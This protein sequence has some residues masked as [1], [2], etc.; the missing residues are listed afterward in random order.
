MNRIYPTAAV[1]TWSWW[2]WG[3]TPANA[4]LLI[5]ATCLVSPYL[6]DY[7]LTLLA[8]AVAL[9]AWDGVKTGRWL[10]WEREVYLSVAILPA[11]MA[12]VAEN[13]GIQVG[14]FAPLAVLVYAYMR[15]S[16]TLACSGTIG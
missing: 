3:V 12:G 11:I 8:A 10:K 13:T 1:V 14:L 15:S 5:A 7:D 9:L 4:A 2:R 6:F 16:R